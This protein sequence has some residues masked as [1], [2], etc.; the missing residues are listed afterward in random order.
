MD[1]QCW[2]Y[3]S[4]VE[5][6]II[7][8][9]ND[10]AYTKDE[11]LAIINKYKLKN[12]IKGNWINTCIEHLEDMQILDEL[13]QEE[14]DALLNDEDWENLETHNSTDFCGKYAV[15]KYGTCALE[16]IREREKKQHFE[17]IGQ[18]REWLTTVTAV[19]AFVLSIISLAK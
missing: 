7:K 4:S 19:A 12:K 14:Y 15:T 10:K 3:L 6:K 16:E 1:N 18:I 8:L 2:I 13:L 5:E 17:I 11:I 9:I